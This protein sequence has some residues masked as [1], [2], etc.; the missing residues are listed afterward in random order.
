MVSIKT[1]GDY[2]VNL[3]NGP[4]CGLGRLAWDYKTPKNIA[5]QV[6]MT[7]QTPLSAV[8]HSDSAL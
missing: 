6:M 7:Q 8:K 5:P 1:T 2:A 3:D 4:G